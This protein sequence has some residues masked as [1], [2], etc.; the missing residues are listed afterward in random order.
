[1][2][3]TD[4][5]AVRRLGILGGTFDPIH[6]GHLAIAEE[7]WERCHLDMVLFMPA[8]DPPHKPDELA[9]AEQRFHMVEM[10]IADNPHFCLSRLELDRPGPSYTVDTLRELHA[11]YPQTELYFIIGTDAA[12]EFFSWRDPQGIL[13]CARIIAAARP[14]IAE[15]VLSAAREAGMLVLHTPGVAVSSTEIRTRANRGWSLR[16]LTP[17]S[18][19]D[20]LHNEGLYRNCEI[21]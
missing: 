15:T 18:V 16:Y 9:S 2:P 10:A 6:Y 12:Q 7:A 1:M 20:F 13:A 8:G 4:L 21:V 11:R 17:P 14:G 3:T 19:I 5:T